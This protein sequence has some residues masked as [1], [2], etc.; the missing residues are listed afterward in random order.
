MN[1]VKNYF[2]E[3]TLYELGISEISAIIEVHDI[4]TNK[5]KNLNFY[6]NQEY[7][8]VPMYGYSD[9]DILIEIINNRLY[10]ADFKFYESLYMIF[11][12]KLHIL[13]DILSYYIK[14][15]FENIEPIVINSDI[16]I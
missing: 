2:R 10:L 11:D 16:H 14:N 8:D 9:C 1:D 15:K 6:I 12:I 7:P 3:L 5:I 4:I 13:I